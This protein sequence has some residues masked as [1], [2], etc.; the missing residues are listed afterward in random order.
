MVFK[1]FTVIFTLE[2]VLKLTAFGKFYFSNGWNNFDL[3]IVVASWVDFG[4]S[5]VDG[6]NVIR[7]F[8]LV[9][10]IDYDAYN[11]FV[12]YILQHAIKDIHNISQ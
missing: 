12:F 4:L 10:P 11:Y 8:R 5:D 9:R 3:V 2:A 7:T 6:V 1:V